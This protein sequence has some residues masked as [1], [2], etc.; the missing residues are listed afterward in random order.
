MPFPGKRRGRAEG[1]PVAE[2]ATTTSSSAARIKRLEKREEENTEETQKCVQKFLARADKILAAVDEAYII[3]HRNHQQRLVPLFT[4]EEVS[5]GDLLGTGGFGQV[6]E[7]NHFTLQNNSKNQQNET[8]SK[9]EVAAVE[10]IVNGNCDNRN[11][12]KKEQPNATN[13]TNSIKMNGAVHGNSPTLVSDALNHMDGNNDYNED[14]DDEEYDYTRRGFGPSSSTA[15]ILTTNITNSN[16]PTGNNINSNGQQQ[17]QPQNGTYILQTNTNM[18]EDDTDHVHYDITQA[19]KWMA[20]EPRRDGYGR[21]AIKKLKENLSE[22][23]QARAMVDLAV[24]AKFLSIVW[25]PNISKSFMIFVNR[26]LLCNQG[27][28]GPIGVMFR[29]SDILF[30]FR[31]CYCDE[32]RPYFIIR[33]T[34]AFYKPPYTNN[35]T[36]S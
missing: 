11:N 3:T 19:R 21:Y 26:Y 9:T 24:E 1:A 18:N 16:D 12:G 14:D 30:Y 25:H 5:I 33:Q 6:Y 17:Q 35:T 28:N 10:T 2:S 7:I 34:F 8:T 36:Q 31:S 29:Q 23:E 13:G 20:R 4:L 22:L 15:T 32:H 27:N